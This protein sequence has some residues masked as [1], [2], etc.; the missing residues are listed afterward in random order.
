[1]SNSCVPSLTAV[2]RRVRFHWSAPQGNL[3]LCVPLLLS[4]SISPLV[5]GAPIGEAK[6]PP[7]FRTEL[8]YEVPPNQGSWVAL[9]LDDRGRLYVSDQDGGLYR[10]TPA[11]I[12]QPVAKTRVEAVPVG[13]GMAQGM[14]FHGGKLYVMLNGQVGAFSSG[15]YRLSDSNGDD[16]LDAVEQL[17]VIEGGGE[18][19]PHALAIGPDGKSLYFCCGNYTKMPSY[20]RCYPNP[21]WRE[22]QLL[23]RLDDPS[24]SGITLRAPGGWIARTD[25]EGDGLRI[26]AMGFRNQYD[27]AFNDDG[28]LFTFDSDMEWDVGTPWY[29]PTRLLHVVPGG[30][31]G[32][33][34]G[35][36]V[37]PDYYP[38]TL[39]AATTAGQGSPTGLAFGTATKFPEKYR[40][41]LFAGDWSY[42]NI[43][44][45]FPRRHGAT[46]RAEVERFASA[47][48][49]AVTDLV[50][51]PQDGALY[52]VVGGRK[53]ASA[54]YR[55]V[56]AGEEGNALHLEVDQGGPL[57]VAA[58]GK[59]G[60]RPEFMSLRRSLEPLMVETP[61]D[62]VDRL[63]PQLAHEDRF[64]RYCA[65]A[66]LERQPLEK[67]RSRALAEPNSAARLA[68]LLAL[69]R[70]GGAV[71]QA[72]LC[73][74]L[75]RLDYARLPLDQR[76]EALRVAALG[77]I[78]LG[79]LSE[80]VRR[81]ALAAL[82]PALAARELRERRELDKLL[83][84]LEAD[85]IVARL[86]QAIDEAATQEEAIDAAVT[87]TAVKTGWSIEHRRRLLV[88][89]ESAC[90]QG[91]GQSHFI[92]LVKAR[93]RFLEGFSES[94]RTALAEWADK[95]L[96]RDLPREKPRARPYVRLWKLDELVP[97]VEANAG[98]RDLVR[99]R[100]LCAE[101]G[102][103]Q[104]HRV[105]G[106]GSVVGPDLTG[107][108]G[109]FGVRDLLQA[110]VEPSHAISDQYRQTI[111]VIDGKS[112]VG[113]ITN[114]N[115]DEVM[116][117]PDMT[118]PKTTATVRRDEIEEERPS[119]ISIMPS[120]LLDTLQ[121][122]EACDL[123]AYLRAA[124]KP[125]QP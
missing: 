42:G 55:I 60:E 48:P 109:R 103:F 49:L 67:W 17:R 104:C 110:I 23:P 87:L 24:G 61:V 26:V 10:V 13:V 111:Y 82:K 125:S 51:R 81:Q 85:G 86:L 62:A 92:Y 119:P 31:Y 91:G 73:S 6:L 53:S 118:D 16:Q 121:T 115:G 19:G 63:W 79:P 95:P 99:G 102:C 47:M 54:M 28:D 3:K 2:C 12:G 40:R 70:T 84:A 39:P 77:V 113:R 88:W 123:V 46:Y 93:D 25:L 94:E 124:V 68:A 74:S 90:R 98:Q 4:L 5:D 29:R 108:G 78:R 37:W 116:I 107:V 27:V 58:A 43:Y 45:F 21:D 7:G 122:D 114:V 72:E 36:G 9:A 96:S 20:D 100:R 105:A 80:E 120:G 101:V 15:I 1:M 50:V 97:L 106:E 117:T 32:W 44:A 14:A 34:S 112:V 75:W 8:V 52:F 57:Q 89:F 66:A 56:W 41:A 64:V 38:D 11:P 18:H 65:R 35:D 76:L 22:D 71:D 83:A 59:N 30:D 69:A 33:R